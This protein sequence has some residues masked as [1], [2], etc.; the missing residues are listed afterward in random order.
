MVKVH[1]P[2]VDYSM[3]A[4]LTQCLAGMHAGMATHIQQG[5]QPYII[6]YN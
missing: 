3:A 6:L 4:T 1:R 2:S 5:S